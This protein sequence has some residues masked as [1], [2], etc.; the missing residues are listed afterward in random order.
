MDF[1]ALD[2]LSGGRAILGIGS[3]IAGALRRIGFDTGRPVA[4]V[5]EAIEIIRI[6][7]AAGS[8][9]ALRVCGAIADGLIV[10]NMTPPRLTRQLAAIV[11]DAATE[12]GRPKPWVVQYVPSA[13]AADGE[14]ARRAVKAAIGEA[15]TLLWPAGDVWPQR[16][17]AAVAESG[18]PRRDFVAALERLRR[19]ETAADVLD[20]RFIAAFAIAGTASECLQQ[21]ARYGETGVDELALTFAGS[22]PADAIAELAAAL[23]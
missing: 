17:A 8:E 22:R 3:G 5:R 13:I 2:E 9:R 6:Y 19:G 18:I 12:A 15:L 14:T 16:R 10:S 20:D 7:M 21:A 11:A 23:P 4:A 1:A